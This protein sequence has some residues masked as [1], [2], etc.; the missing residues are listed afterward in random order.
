MMKSCLALPQTTF[1]QIRFLAETTNIIPSA[2]WWVKARLFFLR[3]NREY[4]NKTM[5]K[6]SQRESDYFFLLEGSLLLLIK[7]WWKNTIGSWSTMSSLLSL[8]SQTLKSKSGS[9]I[10]PSKFLI[11]SNQKLKIFLRARNREFRISSIL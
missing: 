5:M 11:L 8:F 10:I 7:K 9:K 3:K 1:P 4:L 6:Y 2:Y